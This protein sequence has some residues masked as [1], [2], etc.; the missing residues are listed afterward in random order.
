M[1]ALR[2]FTQSNIKTMGWQKIAPTANYDDIESFPIE[3]Q[4]TVKEILIAHVHIGWGKRT[5]CPHMRMLII[6]SI[7]TKFC[8]KFHP[9]R[10]TYAAVAAYVFLKKQAVHRRHFLFVGTKPWLAKLIQETAQNCGAS[11]V[12]HKWVGG[13]ISN[14]ETTSGRLAYL[15]RL[16]KLKAIDGLSHLSKKVRAKLDRKYR[17]MDRELGGM[18]E[19]THSP[20]VVF[21]IDSKK[22]KYAV[23][24]ARRILVP[25]T[26]LVDSNGNPW[27]VDMPV[28]TNASETKAVEFMLNYLSEAIID[29]T[30]LPFADAR[31]PD[32]NYVSGGKLFALESIRTVQLQ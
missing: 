23:A 31:Y 2:N 22:E 32:E 1:F 10:L 25:S 14:W 28:P 20:G 26:G 5:W 21:V 19:M 6:P 27:K 12:T 15:T 11:Y 30:K 7:C 13:L 8:L 3:R 24:E 18:R 17:K 29:G 16:E 4:L 9:K